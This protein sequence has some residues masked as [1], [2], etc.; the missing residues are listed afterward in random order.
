MNII[1]LKKLLEKSEQ[2]K[3]VDFMSKRS[4]D[5]LYAPQ[6]FKN[7]IKNIGTHGNTSIMTS[8]EAFLSTTNKK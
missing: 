3:P 7:Q 6:I 8:N 2:K 5:S 1:E 4:D